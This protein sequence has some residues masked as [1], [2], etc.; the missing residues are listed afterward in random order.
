ME[1][2]EIGRFKSISMSFF[3]NFFSALV[4]DKDIIDHRMSICSGCEFFS[5]QRTYGPTLSWLSGIIHENFGLALLLPEGNI[6]RRW[7]ES[8]F[9][10]NNIALEHVEAGNARSFWERSDILDIIKPLNDL[11][12]VY[13]TTE[14]EEMLQPS[15]RPP[16]EQQQSGY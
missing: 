14:D 5:K 1:K 11:N 10:N 12:I 9:Y 16:D 8:D 4:A 2:N 3:E 7:A 13:P 15:D 6:R